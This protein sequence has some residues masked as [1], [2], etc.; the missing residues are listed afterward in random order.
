MKNLTQEE[1]N[2]K[3]NLLH[4]D[5][6]ELI[7]DYKNMK[8]DIICLCNICGN[9]FSL[10][11]SNY[12]LKYLCPVCCRYL[13]SGKSKKQTTES[14]IEKA[15]KVHGDKYDY[16][17]VNYINSSTKVKIICRQC[18]KI[19][20]QRP[21]DH[22]N[23]K[24]GCPECGKKR[25]GKLIA[26]KTRKTTEQYVEEAIALLGNT[27]D[28]S[29]VN[30]VNNKTNIEIICKKH[31]SFWQRPDHHLKDFV[32]CPKCRASGPEQVIIN[33]LDSNKI[34]YDFQKTFEECKSIKELPFDFYIPNINLL[35]EYQGEQH[36]KEMRFEGTDLAYRQK[37]DKLK[38][39]FAISKGFDF[40]EIPYW[41]NKNIRKILDENIKKKCE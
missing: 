23:K 17:M 7:S 35:I 11:A 8:S 15:K 5:F 41:E 9:V 30:Y 39:D 3:F 19:F 33:Y 31:G 36:Y 32:G 38:K 4:N 21:C 27:F 20:E 13:I 34:E 10:L 37:C 14:F 12:K 1:F 2:F 22:I 29:R 25:R 40:L 24:Y 18:G 16:S 6:V 28:Y 26:K